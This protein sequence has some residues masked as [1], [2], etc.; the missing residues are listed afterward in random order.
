MSA[1]VYRLSVSKKE[2]SASFSIPF[3]PHTEA[4]GQVLVFLSKHSAIR[5]LGSASRTTHPDESSGFAR[6]CY[7]PGTPGMYIDITT[8][9]ERVNDA[10]QMIFRDS[11]SAAD[12]LCGDHTAG[13]VPR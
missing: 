5:R 10:Y 4:I 1:T 11:V 12:L 6:Q 3:K 7:A 8:P 9:R 2:F 13:F